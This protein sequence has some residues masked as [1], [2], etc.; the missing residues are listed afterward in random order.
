D[1]DDHYGVA[2]LPAGASIR[3]S[4]GVD[5]AR[6]YTLHISVKTANATI[7]ITDGDGNALPSQT[8]TGS[9]SVWTETSI[10]LGLAPGTTYTI[11]I[12]NA[13]VST[14]LVDDLWLWWVPKTRAE[15]AAIT[16]RQLAALASDAGYSTTASGAQ[17]EGNYTDA[18]DAGLR[19]VGAIDPESDTPD[20]RGLTQALLDSCLQAIE[21]AMLERLQRYYA[22]M[23]DTEA[24]PIKEKLSQIAA[25]LKSLT[26]SGQGGKAGAV[27]VRNLRRSAADYELLP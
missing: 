8:G 27:V 21:R 13:G 10:T 19:S 20:I 17:T 24:G 5:R 12:S 3:Q 22:L 4:F 18:V 7:V 26:S 14:I 1:G 2:S 25:G 6:A 15:L 23:V 11:T 16:A 9:A